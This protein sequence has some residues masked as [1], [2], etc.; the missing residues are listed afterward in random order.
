MIIRPRHS[1]VDPSGLV[2]VPYLREWVFQSSSILDLIQIC[3]IAFGQETP[4]YSCQQ[5][6]QP[7][8]QPQSQPQSQY[9]TAQRV[10]P[11]PSRTSPVQP[12]ATHDH[13]P[14]TAGPAPRGVQQGMGSY[15]RPG[16][17]GQGSGQIGS[18]PSPA[19][20]LPDR[21]QAGVAGSPA[22]ADQRMGFG[23]LE[24]E[25]GG[26]GAPGA[27]AKPGGVT[28]TLTGPLAGTLYTGS[29]AGAG[30]GEAP[31]KGPPAGA[32]GTP[33]LPRQR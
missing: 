18:F 1:H 6:R 16:L 25:G 29:G 23:R 32:T 26:W 9:P 13:R 20:G 10:S 19:R 8:P 2:D 31:L 17:G 3:C 28:G 30:G 12:Q 22:G 33:P 15:D 21:A 5:Q 27:D 7:P 24:R 4:L 11:P 14:S